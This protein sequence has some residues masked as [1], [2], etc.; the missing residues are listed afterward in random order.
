M[1]RRAYLSVIGGTTVLTGCSAISEDDAP[2]SDLGGNNTT[3]P[4]GENTS[5]DPSVESASFELVE[6]DI[7]EVMNAD[8]DASISITVEN[9]GGSAGS[10]SGQAWI[11]KEETTLAGETFGLYND[12][13]DEGRKK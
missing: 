12:S 2:S 10:F 9:T 3:N 5:S 11:K 7:P 13:I 6:S 4:P 8:E 1:K